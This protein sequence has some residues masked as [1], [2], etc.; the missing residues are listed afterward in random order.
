MS[1]AITDMR[2]LRFL[3]YEVLNIEELT[4]AAVYEDH[5]KETFDMALDTADQ[6]AREVFLPPF[7]EFDKEGA[8]FEDG[9]VTVPEGMREIWK[10]CKEGGWFSVAVDAESGGQ[11]F[12][13][14]I[15]T[16]TSF[17]FAGANNSAHIYVL[18]CTGAAQLIESYGTDKLK[19]LYMF[20]MYSGEWAATMALTEPQAGT[21]LADIKTTAVKAPDG[22]HYLI[23]GTK[24]FISSGDHDLAPNII[25]PVL[26]R[27]EGAPPGTKG[28]SLFLVPKYRLDENGDPAESNDVDTMG[29][30]HKMGLKGSSTATLDFGDH[31][32]CHGWLLG[33]PHKGLKY[34][35]QMM[36]HARLYTGLQ[37]VA[38]AS[39]G[40]QV[41]LEW[42]HEREQSR[43]IMDKDPTTP[44]VPI[45]IHPDVRIML[46]RQKSFV[47]AALGLILYTAKLQ[48][49]L[50]S[51]P[52]EEKQLL[53]ELITPCIKAHGS[54]GAFDSLRIAVQVLA[55]AGFCEEMPVSQLL[56]DCKVFSIYEGANGVQAM[57]LL[58]RKVARK[59]GAAVRVCMGEMGKTLEEAA[60]LEPLKAIA[61]KVKDLQQEVGAVTMQLG[62]I[63]MSGDLRHYISYASPYLEMFSQMLMSWQLLMQAVVAQKAL[64]AGTTEENFYQA[65]VETARFYANN[66]IPHAMAT[67]QILKSQERTALDFK[68]EWFGYQAPQ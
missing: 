43:D 4:K 53:L 47:E 22:D 3:L 13:V 31:D 54:D 61:D 52:N 20:K 42:A 33:E 1:D 29:I 19:E 37:A 35:F 62:A 36:N 67:A 16:A 32:N 65:K 55:G 18:L 6:V 8:Q 26:A 17:L 39:R 51:E 2:N 11:Q 9:K 40:Y 7:Q 38:S 25:H 15:D 5:S 41:S 63:G 21:S 68:K 57:D 28:I 27:I 12:P 49:E 10:Q 44:Q 58:G 34:M 48:D 64:D 56:R 24:C 50:R 45:V 59:G 14:A 46:L 60:Q 30:E 23:K 66:V